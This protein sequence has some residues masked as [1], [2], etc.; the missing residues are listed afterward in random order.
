M[1]CNIFGKGAGFGGAVANLFLF[2]IP[3]PACF[4]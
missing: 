2:L 1:N 4:Q 3:Y